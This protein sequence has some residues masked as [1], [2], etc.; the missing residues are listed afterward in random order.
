MAEVSLILM[1]GG[2][3]GVN[4]SDAPVGHV[5]TIPG[6]CTGHNVTLLG[7]YPHRTS[8]VAFMASAGSS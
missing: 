6:I 5:A 3:I 4:Y 2:N 7:E 1:D 8:N